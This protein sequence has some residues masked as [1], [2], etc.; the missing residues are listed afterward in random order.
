MTLFFGFVGLWCIVLFPPLGYFL[1]LIGVETFEFPHGKALWGGLA[2]NAAITFVRSPLLLL[3]P[4]HTD[5]SSDCRS[6][7]PSISAPCS[8]PPPSP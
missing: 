8:S 7:T 6:P 5:H 2:I 3:R 4:N 1:H